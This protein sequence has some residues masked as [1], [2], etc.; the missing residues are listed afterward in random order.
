MKEKKE[1]LDEVDPELLRTFDKLVSSCC[2][3][4]CA[5]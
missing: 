4:C 3:I 1:S 2:A 5:A